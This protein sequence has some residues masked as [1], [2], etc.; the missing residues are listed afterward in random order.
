MIKYQV[1]SIEDCVKEIIDLFELHYDEIGDNPEGVK[2]AVDYDAFCYLEDEGRLH[3]VTARVDEE[4]VGYY[5]SVLCNMLHFKGRVNAFND[6]I[7]IKKE[8][9]KGSLA[10]RMIKFA[11]RELR[12]LGVDRM[13][14]HMKTKQPF[15]K[16]C[17]HLGMTCT[18]RH[19]V[20]DF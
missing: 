5:I 20:K 9:R 18:E 3:I 17:E 16:L 7:Y 19:Y 2:L 1:E 11:E 13:T 14:I 15:D 12:A 8:F 6:A 10:V 4:L